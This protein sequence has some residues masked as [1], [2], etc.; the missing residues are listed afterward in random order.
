MKITMEIIDSF[1][2]DDNKSLKIQAL[3]GLAIIAVV[4]IHTTPDGIAQVICRPYLNFAVAL[5]LFLSG[6]LSDAKKWKPL[7]RLAKILIPYAIWTFVY[8]LMQTYRHPDGII[9][10]YFRHLLLGDAVAIMYYVFVYCEF[11]LLIP[12]ID[13]LA[14]SRYKY[15]GFIVS[16]LEI[17]CM[18]LMLY[19]PD[20]KPTFHD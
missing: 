2:I 1:S 16:P 18:R 7:K 5:F 11:T 12:L 8:T 14:K 10:N 13:K 3:R 15:L 17:I 20:G 19:I 6:M 9:A 4:F